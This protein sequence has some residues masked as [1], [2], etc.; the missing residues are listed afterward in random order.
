[1]RAAL[2]T[3]SRLPWLLALLLAAAI[4]SVRGAAHGGHAH[5]RSRWRRA[6]PALALVLLAPFLAEIL[7]GAMRWSYPYGVYSRGDHM[8]LR[9]GIALGMARNFS[10]SRLPRAARGYRCG[11]VLGA[12]MESTGPGRF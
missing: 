9:L 12:G 7:S 10:F 3:G 11:P 2:W 6:A 1:M 4:W 8:G 5:D